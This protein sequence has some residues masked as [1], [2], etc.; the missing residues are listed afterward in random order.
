MFD[1][2]LLSIKNVMSDSCRKTRIQNQFK[3][4]YNRNVYREKG[5]VEKT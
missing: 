3:V 4:L 1:S 5:E 2:R